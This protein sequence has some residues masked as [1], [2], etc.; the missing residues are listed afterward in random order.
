MQFKLTHLAYL[1]PAMIFYATSTGAHSNLSVKPASEATIAFQKQFLATLPTDNDS[2]IDSVNR[3]FITTRKEPIIPSGNGGIAW[4]LTRFDFVKGPAP[5]TVN[6]SL[7]RQISLLRHHGLYEVGKDVWQIRGFDVSNMTIIRGKTGW[8]IIDP[9]NTRETAAAALELVNQTLGSRPVSAVMYTHTHADH[10]GGVRSV[11]DERDVRKGKVVVYAPFGFNEE[12]ASENIM[13]AP[14]TVRRGIFQF[15]VGIKPGVSGNMGTGLSGSIAAGEITLIAPTKFVSKTGEKIT[16]DGVPFEFQMVSG[17][18]APTEFNVY[19]PDSR[20]FLSAEMSTCALHNLLTP[21]GAKVRDAKLWASYLDEALKLYG[22]RTD[23]L[24]SSHCWP[25]YG[26]QEVT[27]LLSAQ[28]DNYTYL[29][30]QTVR[31][32]NRGETPTEIAEELTQPKQ[33]ADN[34]FNHGYYGTYS[35]NSKAVYQYYLGWYDAVPANLNPHPPVDRA[36][37]MVQAIGGSKKILDIAT[38]AMNTG[39]YRWSSDLLNQLVFAEPNNVEAKAMLADSYEQQ[40]YQS[41][42]GLWRNQFLSAA[43]ELRNGR[44]KPILKQNND[45]L[46]AVP[47]KLLMDSVATRFSPERNGDKK[48]FINIVMPE[49]METISLEITGVVMLPRN[50]IV[51]SPDATITASR[52]QILDL[53]YPMKPLNELKSQGLKIKGDNAVVENWL[54]A[55]DPIFNDF[56]IALP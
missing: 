42:S 1:I 31:L 37:R 54:A 53:L 51:A 18:E 55:I 44:I 16:V 45:M 20:L 15:G 46:A 25:R 47:T 3:G 26:S 6:P 2:D 29:H 41:E 21:R 39:D 38:K 23:T 35:H 17:S 24:I 4:D 40:G 36:K 50:G 13:A 10:F 33:L 30:D 8:I 48:Y 7:W 19:I 14:A 22:G 43:N 9:L 52:T 5:A 27:K 34:W 28:R 32:M 12:S 11:V 56:N 49:R